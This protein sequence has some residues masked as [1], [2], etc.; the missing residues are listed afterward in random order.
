M[1][2]LAVYARPVTPTAVDYLLQPH[3]PGINSAAVLGRLVNM[4]F[5]RKEGGR[6]YLHPVD[7]AYAFG[8]VPVGEEADREEVDAPPFTQYA[9]L[10]RAAEYYRQTRRPR[11]AW[12]T[13]DDLAS[14]LAEFELRSAG[15]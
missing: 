5:V 3:V 8:Q 13:L 4:Q 2:A 12:K 14:Q 15:G 9:L 11:E 1:E 6:Y 10:H 7:R